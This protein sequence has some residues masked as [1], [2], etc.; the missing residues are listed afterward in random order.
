[1]TAFAALAGV[2]AAIGFV[3]LLAVLK[4]RSRVRSLTAEA[5]GRSV[6]PV[7][8][9]QRPGEGSSIKSRSPAAAGA[10]RL[11][12]AVGRRFPARAP[13]GLAR[14]LDAAGLDVTVA[15]LMALKAGAGVAG[16]A[17]ASLL[18]AGMPGRVGWLLVAVGPLAGFLA[19]DAWL[20]RRTLRRRRTMEQQLGDV[21]ELLRVAV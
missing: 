12:A 8:A 11:L 3:D 20:R 16:L 19:P 1:M 13:A 21:L 4:S 18:G 17:S 6:L 9:G 2:L 7:P 10:I 5:A 15:E 14:R